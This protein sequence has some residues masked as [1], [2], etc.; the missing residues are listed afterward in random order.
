MEYFNHNQGFPAHNASMMLPVQAIPTS[1]KT[2]KWFHATMDSLENIGV[3]QISKNTRFRDYY[4]MKDGKLATMELSSLIPQLKSVE[5]IRAEH[6]I[7][8]FLKHYDLIGV[9][10]NVLVGQLSGVGDKYLVQSS[11]EEEVNQYLDMKTDLLVKYMAQSFDER[12]RKK[13]LEQGVDPDYDNFNS[14]EEQQQYQQQVE[15]M[16]QSMTPP[17]IESFMNTRWKTA[18]VIWGNDTLRND[19][20]RFHMDEMDRDL[21]VD[22][23]LTGRCFINYLEGYDYYKPEVWSPINTFYSETLDSRYPQY[24]D[25][26]GRVHYFTGGQL[27]NRYGGLLTAEEKELLL[28]GRSYLFGDD[29][30]IGGGFTGTRRRGFT[31]HG[32]WKNEVAPFKGYNDYQSIVAAEDWTGEPMGVMRT[33][34]ENGEVKEKPAFLPRIGGDMYNPFTA[35]MISNVPIRSDLYR[36]TEAYWVSYKQVFCVTYIT[37]TGM[38][39]QEIVTDELFGE[40]LKENGIKKIKQCMVDGTKDPEVNTY[41]V[42]Y[43][44]EVRRGIKITGSNTTDKAIYIDGEPIKKQIKGYGNQYDFVLPVAGYVGESLAD[45]IAPYQVMY[46][47]ALNDLYNLMEKEIGIFFLTDMKFFPSEYKDFGGVEDILGA[48]T[49]VARSVGIMPL[50]VSQQ[51]LSNGSP[52]NQFATYDLSLSGQMQSRMQIASWAKSEAYAMLGIT[53]QALGMQGQ[54]ETAEGV[55]QGA[56]A[57]QV[58]TQSFFDEFEDFKARSLDMHLAVAQACQEEGKDVTLLTARDDL[59]RAYI[60]ISDD[61][62]TLR[63]LNVYAMINSDKRKKLEQM[64]QYLLQMNTAGSNMID[65]AGIINSDSM[66]ELMGVARKAVQYQ[67]MVRQQQQESNERMAKQQSDAEMQKMQLEHKQ[68]MEQIQLQGE[69][70]IRRESVLASGR[71]ADSN[72]DQQSLNFV[73]DMTN[74]NLKSAEMDSNNELKNKEL[75]LKRD[76]A[77]KDFQL[78]LKELKAKTDQLEQRADEDATKRFTSVINKN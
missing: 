30:V 1:K 45:R 27:V 76:I 68:K 60:T 57:M 36:V 46:N 66:I 71:A 63:N 17:E 3:K 25:Y 26:I 10:C 35:D 70:N 78:K 72:A 75:D 22:K 24:G 28:G 62:L 61:D 14:P 19:R 31:H 29:S 18:A 47:Y 16:K 48:V 44:P 39:Q 21:F 4:L 69:M 64:K 77:D 32:W 7:P 51:G 34:D 58:Q 43:L 55:K 15:Q 9:I 67:E 20:A 49:D 2:K 6:D 40:F 54:Y 74:A 65:L 42:D 73:K 50:D 8:S 53:P 12:I 5:D 13:L 52:F 56:S 41:F 11:D 33:Y 37:E 38:V 23:I 59:S